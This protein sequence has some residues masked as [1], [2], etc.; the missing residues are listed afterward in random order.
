MKEFNINMPKGFNDA[1]SG[2]Y[3]KVHVRG[4][5]FNFFLDNINEYLA[6]GSMITSG[7]LP[8]MKTLSR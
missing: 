7:R 1:S 2:D 8:S 4:N 3:K 6:R 5:Y